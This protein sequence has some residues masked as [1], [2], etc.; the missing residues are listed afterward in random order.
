ME[1]GVLMVEIVKVNDT[2]V[3]KIGMQEIRQVYGKTQL[4]ER[5]ANLETQLA[6]VNE[7][8]ELFDEKEA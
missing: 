5:K 3:A 6:E 1:G 4:V 2:T 7:L 8:L